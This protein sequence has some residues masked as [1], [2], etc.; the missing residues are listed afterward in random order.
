MYCVINKCSPSGI[1]LTADESRFSSHREYVSEIGVKH[2][3][4]DIVTSGGV[5]I[6]G[7]DCGCSV[8]QSRVLSKGSPA[9]RVLFPPFDRV[10]V[11]PTDVCG[12]KCIRFPCRP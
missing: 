7:I 5:K 12:A 2:D 11:A 8:R 6:C 1:V 3:I 4:V 10:C 9:A